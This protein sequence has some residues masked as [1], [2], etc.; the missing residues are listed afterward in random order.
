MSR[1]E[2]SWRAWVEEAEC[3]VLLVRNELTVDK[4]PWNLVCY[5][6]Q[7]AA[8]K[9]LKALIVFHGREPRKIHDLIALLADCLGDAP[10]LAAFEEDL[11]TLNL[12]SVEARYP[13]VGPRPHESEART[14]VAL[15][16]RFRD[17]ARRHLGE[18]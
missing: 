9:Y 3:D 13:D 11:R 1:R 4:A 17:V 6:A 16:E 14:A 5:H 12:Y 18:A 10:D 2:A 8:E 7:Q 15:A